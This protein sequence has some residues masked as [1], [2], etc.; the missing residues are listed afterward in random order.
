MADESEK[1]LTNGTN[2]SVEEDELEGIK[3]IRLRFL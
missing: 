3:M 1:I 2:H